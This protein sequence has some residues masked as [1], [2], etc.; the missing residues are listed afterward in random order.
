MDGLHFIYFSDPMCSWCWG[1]SPVVETLRQRYR[2]ILPLRLVMGGLRPGTDQ[3][4]TPEAR[5]QML[6]YWGQVAKVTGQGFTG[7]ALDQ[8][9]FTYDTDPAARAV[10]LARRTDP[11]AG[12]DYLA[13]VQR[14]FYAEGRNVTDFEVL[15]YIAAEQGFER[16]PFRAALDDEGLKAET[17]R[18]YAVSQRAGVSGFPTLILGPNTDGTFAMVTQGYNAGEPIVAAID[19]MLAR[20]QPAAE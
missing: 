19:A 12:L 6:G 13:R 11:D 16:A 9:G 4:L 8:P 17:W 20:A 2:D 3:A 10:V 18:D 15:A 1:F 14:A 7:A 5:E